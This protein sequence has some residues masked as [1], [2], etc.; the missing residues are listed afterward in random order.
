MN[1]KKI[2]CDQALRRIFA[3]VDREL[4]EEERTAMQEHLHT[5]RSCF[6]RM[7]FERL[8]KSKV[9]A[10]RDGKAT[11]SVSE[12]VTALLKDF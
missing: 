3:Y 5:C 2:D 4:G 9:G 6:S 11:P 8:L 7:E 10:L 12:R 1:S